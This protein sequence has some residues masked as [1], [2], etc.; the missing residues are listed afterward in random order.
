MM[1]MKTNQRVWCLFGLFFTILA[2]CGGKPLQISYYSLA[3][4]NASAPAS[5]PVATMPGIS[6]G[7]GPVHVPELLSRSQILTRAGD[8]RLIY[9]ET[10]RWAGDVE[11]DVSSTVRENISFLLGTERVAVYP[12]HPAFR[13]T[14]RVVLDIL[15]FDGI[16][17]EYAEVIVRWAINDGRSKALLVVKKTVARELTGG[18]TY[19]DLVKAQS[20]ALAVV[21][22]EISEELAQRATAEHEE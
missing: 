3:A 9:A 17:G 15:A 21:S 8:H 19:D 16:R 14:Y 18:D 4:L 5:V 13:P 10:H 20:T 11:K 12:W 2:A 6:I 7:I 1:Q 22:R